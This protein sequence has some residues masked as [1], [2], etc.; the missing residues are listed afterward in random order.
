ME[1]RQHDR[2]WELAADENG[3][4]TVALVHQAPK[5]GKPK[6]KEDKKAP[7]EKPPVAKEA[8]NYPTPQDLT[9]K[10][11]APNKPLEQLKAEKEE[12]KKAKAKAEAEV[13]TRKS[14]STATP[15][16]KLLEISVRVAAVKP[17]SLDN[18]WRHIFFTYDG[19][20]FASGVK[21]YVDGVQ[22]ATQVLRDDLSKASIRTDAPMQLGWR[23]PDEDPAKDAR[24]QDIRL[25]AR[26]L[27]PDEVNRLPFEDYVAEITTQP[28]AQ[29]TQD[30]WHVITEFYLT[31][32]D[33]ICRRIKREMAH[34]DEQ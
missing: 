13:K 33:P 26:A 17:L 23:N 2:G 3:T 25:Y 10:D 7:R 14:Q 5:K 11:L 31:D 1:S 8:L 20:G 21:I 34:L 29:W 16:E 18:A 19:S 32:V 6:K 9:K 12:E 15:D 22:V 28:A 30:A 24:Y 27:T 4:L